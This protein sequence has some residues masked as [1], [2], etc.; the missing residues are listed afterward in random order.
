M[1]RIQS[2]KC[3]WQ[4]EDDTA[5]CKMSKAHL[6]I[7]IKDEFF[8]VCIYTLRFGLLGT[9]V[10]R[11]CSFCHSDRCFLRNQ[12]GTIRNSPVCLER[13]KIHWGYRYVLSALWYCQCFLQQDFRRTRLKYSRWSASSCLSHIHHPWHHTVMFLYIISLPVCFHTLTP[14]GLTLQLPQP[15]ALPCSPPPSQPVVCTDIWIFVF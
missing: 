5:S 10:W 11:W 12:W 6:Y 3:R 9:P 2:N 14:S 7:N 8:N 4:D 15:P 13:L 1:S